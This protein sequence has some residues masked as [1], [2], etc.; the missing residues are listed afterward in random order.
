VTA[1]SVCRTASRCSSDLRSPKSVS[2]LL[3][4]SRRRNVDPFS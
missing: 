3:K 4:T 2:R 1:A